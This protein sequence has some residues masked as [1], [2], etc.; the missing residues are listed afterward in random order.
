MS[1]RVQTYSRKR[2][3]WC[4]KCPNV[5]DPRGCSLSTTRSR[6]TLRKPNV[7][8]RV[9]S[10]ATLGLGHRGTP[11]LYR[12]CPKRAR[13]KAAPL[14]AFSC[15]DT[16]DTV[17]HR[18]QYEV[19]TFAEYRGGGRVKSLPAAMLTALVGSLECSHKMLSWEGGAG[20]KSASQIPARAIAPTRAFADSGG[21]GDLPS[22]GS[23]N[24][25]RGARP[26]ECFAGLTPRGERRM[27]A[28]K[29]GRSGGRRPGAG[30]PVE[31]VGF[32]S[33]CRAVM[34]RPEIRAAIER[35][36]RE[37]P[38]FALKIAEHG[39][40][41]PPQSLDVNQGATLEKPINVIYRAFYGDP[42]VL[43]PARQ[44]TPG[45]EPQR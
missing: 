15:R 29:K 20:Q 11:A 22:Q 17:G 28:G 6:D 2:V 45:A 33:W 9:P 21:G 39:Y 43:P 34:E 38:W 16:R 18:I 3:P 10:G 5:E 26:F 42:E 32:R 13:R 31:A 41:R 36:A 12:M 30:R 25:P 19:C 40:G 27:M 44:A 35:H 14:F 4:P 7:S 1:R 8:Q 23:R 24:A 37:D